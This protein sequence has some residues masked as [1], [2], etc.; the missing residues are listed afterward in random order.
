MGD[1]IGGKSTK[2]QVNN[3]NVSSNLDID[4]IAKAVAQAIGRVTIRSGSGEAYKDTFSNERS[5]EE[6]A[7]SMIVQRGKNESNFD[8]LG[9]VKETKKD[10]E[11][12]NK[13]IDLLRDI[14]D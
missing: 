11:S 2:G 14:Q 4:A 7:K 6:L 1:Y 13:T 10:K 3:V 9:G 5:M 12:T 8:N